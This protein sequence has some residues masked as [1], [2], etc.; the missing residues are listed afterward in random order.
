MCNTMFKLFI[1]IENGKTI[2]S[3]LEYE[4]IG[5]LVP[6]LGITNLDVIAKLNAVC[7]DIG[8]DTIEVGA[9]IG[10]AMEAGIAEFGD[11]EAAFN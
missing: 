1:Q 5:L 11:S 3:P 2:V 10:V 7:N 4:T 9:A 8:V 6:N